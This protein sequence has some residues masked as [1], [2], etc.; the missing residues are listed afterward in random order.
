MIF[1]YLIHEIWKY[2]ERPTL[3]QANQQH[4]VVKNLH[5]IKISLV[6]DKGPDIN[7]LKLNNNV[8]VKLLS[9]LPFSSVFILVSILVS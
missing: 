3:L 7:S 9:R 1:F 6:R 5:S 8:P 2:V 4:V